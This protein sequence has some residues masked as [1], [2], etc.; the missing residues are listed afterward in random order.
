MILNPK[1]EKSPYRGRGDT[2][3]P[4]PPGSVA[5]LPRLRYII[6]FSVFFYFNFHACHLLSILISCKQV[7]YTLHIIVMEDLYSSADFIK[8]GSYASFSYLNLYIRTFKN[9][10]PLPIFIN[11][12][13]SLVHFAFIGS[14]TLE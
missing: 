7:W 11:N 10:H 8:F 5:S 9:S 3:L 14:H 2:P 13:T 4:H 6:F 1:I 12:D